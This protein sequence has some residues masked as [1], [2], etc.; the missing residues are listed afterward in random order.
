M[1]SFELIREIR[2]ACA[3]ECLDNLGGW[4]KDMWLHN[5][6][7]C[8]HHWLYL[9]L[10][11]I[12]DPQV[13]LVLLAESP[14]NTNHISSFDP[15]LHCPS[16]NQSHPEK[17]RTLNKADQNWLPVLVHGWA[18]L[19]LHHCTIVRLALVKLYS[20][21]AIRE[22]LTL[23]VVLITLKDLLFFLVGLCNH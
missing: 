23:K 6:H 22:E 15:E 5:Y 10:V 4:N 18:Q 11:V 7:T 9:L 20:K 12:V 17:N 2:L 21:E 19:E 13:K 16:A 14:N 1:D 3:W 8:P